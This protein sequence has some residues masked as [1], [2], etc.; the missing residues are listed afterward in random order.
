MSKNKPLILVVDDEAAIRD[1][2][3]FALE[4]AGMKVQAAANAQEALLRI[5][6]QRPDI[7]LVDW[8]MPGISGLKLTRRLRKDSFTEDIPIIMLTAKV[9]EDDKVAGLEAGTDDYVTKPFSPRELLARIHA[10]LRRSSPTDERGQ[11]IV[12]KITLD[13]LSRRALVQDEEVSLGPTEY[14]LLEFFMSHTGRAFSRTQILDHVWG[15]N[16]YLE[17]RTVDVH[18]RRLR[19]ALEPYGAKEYLQT[20]RGH[21]YRF[22]ADT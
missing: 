20:V 21:G 7:M 8:M 19:K 2:I 14:R 3:R 9:S 4:R 11:L 16:A 22:L 17:E 5:S 15:A 13:T 6:E 18:I 12:G 10:V 1:M